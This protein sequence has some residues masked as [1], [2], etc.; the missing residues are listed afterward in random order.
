MNRQARNS[1]NGTENVFQTLAK[2]LF[3]VS[4]PLTA[5]S[6]CEVQFKTGKSFVSPEWQCPKRCR[7]AAII[8]K[9]YNFLVC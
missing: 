9:N 6:C 5:V 4:F 3:P 2:L 1:H 8:I 7:Q